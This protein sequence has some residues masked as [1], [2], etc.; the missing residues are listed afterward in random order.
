MRED[1]A[2]NHLISLT[3][4]EQKITA[5][6]VSLQVSP[7]AITYLT[8]APSRLGDADEAAKTILKLIVS[9]NLKSIL[10]LTREFESKRILKV[11]QKNLS[12]LPVQI[13]CFPFPSEMTA[14]NWFLSDD[15][16]REV[17]YEYI[18]Y[19]YY[20]IRGII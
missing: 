9:E 6:L 11:Y 4:R 20:F 7:D 1:K 5:H 14:S 3:D 2:D 19:L 12:S 15:G 16:F 10:L 18:R 13:S 17:A 8:I